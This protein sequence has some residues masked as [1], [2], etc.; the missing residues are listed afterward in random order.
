MLKVILK[1]VLNSQALPHLDQLL[2]LEDYFAKEINIGLI[3]TSL[4]TLLRKSDKT[5][6][7]LN[8]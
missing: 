3:S 8:S 7:M 5:N 6:Y 4:S 2:S 1:T